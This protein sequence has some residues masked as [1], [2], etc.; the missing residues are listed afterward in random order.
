[1]KFSV[2]LPTR[3]RLKYLGYAVETVRRQDY[4]DWELIVSDNFSTEDIRGHVEG[5][6]D[7]RI[8]YYRT[9]QFVP[10]TENWNSAL[11]R[12]TVES[13]VMLGDDD[14]LLPSYF[15]NAKRHIEAFQSPDLLHIGA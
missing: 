4:D 2:P 6:N 15:T 9:D 10:V 14:G 11:E 3:D 1:M 8:K 5:L 13:V 12:S 7:S